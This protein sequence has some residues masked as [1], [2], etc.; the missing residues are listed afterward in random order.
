MKLK[1]PEFVKKIIDKFEKN[2]FEIYVVGGVVRDILLKRSAVD[3][4]FTTNA[5]PKQILVLFP[6]G[7]YDNQFGT[8]GVVNPKEKKKKV[9]YGKPPIYEITTFRK[10]IGYTDRRRP[11]KVVWGKAV[12]K[13]LVRRDFTINAMAL[14]RV[15]EQQFK[16]I[17]PHNGQKD[18]KAKLIRA[19]GDPNKRFQ[20]DALR[21]MRAVRIATQ[22]G[23]NIEEKTFIAI[24]KNVNLIDHISAER[25]R[26]ELLKLLSYKHAADGYLILRNSG[27]A[28]KILPEVEKMFGVEQKSPGRH[29]LDDV[30]THAI[31]SLKANKSPD[32][33]VNLAIL[34]HDIGKPVVV[35]KDK[36]GTITFYNHEVVGAS[37]ARNIARRL[38]FSK[39]DE[40]RLFILV[41]W[42]QFSVDE[43]QTNKAFRRFIR[44]VG[45]E[46][47]TDILE[48]RRAD[49]VGGGARETSWRFER[50]K[51][52]L[53][54][55]QKQ[56][57]SVTDLKVNGNEVMKTLGIRP[58][59][60]VGRILNQLFEEVAE[61]KKKNEKKYL[62]KRI[63]EIGKKLI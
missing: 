39:K 27:L 14:K 17:D 22:L 4:D 43:R 29:H 31:K 25:I 59:P 24:K 57:F 48:V 46:N 7:F 47:L 21:M 3:W 20:E 19:V 37:I 18:I 26:D 11:D 50:F 6:D 15:K 12:E 2:G 38:R 35:G 42:H 56:P 40:Q 32:P 62:L 8:V 54:E 55:V 23:F 51:K 5:I 60:A 58:G 61:D 52:K 34:L 63:K 44:N 33:I 41:R 30:G 45:K 36:K 10:E 28:E 16:L 9:Y 13:D 49:R 53:V 1:L